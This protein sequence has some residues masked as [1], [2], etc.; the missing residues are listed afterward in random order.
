MAEMVEREDE[1]LKKGHRIVRA[2]AFIAV[3]LVFVFAAYHLMKILDSY[4]RTDEEYRKIAGE[5]TSPAA[6]DSSSPDAAGQAEAGDGE[7]GPEIEDADPPLAVDWDGLK[8]ENS[9]IVAWIYVD[10]TGISYP[11]CR[12]DN[13]SYYL[14]HTFRKT[15]LYAGSIFEDYLCAPDFSDPNTFVYGHNM[16]SGSMFA[17]L[18][19]LKS[20]SLYDSNPFFWILTPNGNFR[21]HIFSVFD[22]TAGSGVYQLFNTHDDGFLAYCREM[23]AASAVK[24]R[25]PLSKDDFVVTLSTCNTAAGADIRTVVFGRCC[26]T[27]KPEKSG[28]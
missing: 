8:K 7:D 24:N 18:K 17:S 21:Y 9:D 10:A 3:M 2:A 11:V 15:Y 23:K 4:R 13:N 14:H 20:Q 19:R 1:T 28:T 6:E 27:Q 25:V 26:S 12:T 16:K 22:T 5:Y